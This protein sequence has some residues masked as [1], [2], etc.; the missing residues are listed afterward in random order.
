MDRKEELVED[1]GRAG[2][3][4]ILGDYGVNLEMPFREGQRFWSLFF[5]LYPNAHAF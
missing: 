1:A 2:A 3:D 4:D 5:S